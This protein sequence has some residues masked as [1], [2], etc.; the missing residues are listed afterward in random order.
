MAKAVEEQVVVQDRCPE[1][2]TKSS[3][4]GNMDGD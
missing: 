2:G 3:Q 4:N 1:R